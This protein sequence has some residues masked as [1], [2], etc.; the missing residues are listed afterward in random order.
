MRF[1][2]EHWSRRISH[3][4]EVPSVGIGL[5]SK[6]LHRYSQEV[7]ALALGHNPFGSRPTRFSL[8]RIAYFPRAGVAFSR[9]Q[10]NANSFVMELLATVESCLV[11]ESGDHV[12][13]P[14]DAEEL[15]LHFTVGRNNIRALLRIRASSIVAVRRNPY[16][17]T[18]SAF[19][20]KFRASAY[21]QRFGDFEL[22]PAGFEGFVRWLADGGLHANTH[23]AP[24]VH[25]LLPLHYYD[26]LF[27][28]EDLGRTLRAF[29][30]REELHPYLEV[31]P[32]RLGSD[33]SLHNQHAE[34]RLREY[35]SAEARDV[36]AELFRDDFTRLGYS[37][38]IT[39]AYA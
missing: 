8:S 23:W 14:D 35:Y 29:L 22:T 18:L 38:D 2:D 37:T 11:G 36:I 24:Q 16:A 31:W 20:D 3:D 28:Q 33:E 1:E 17:R 21:R 32:Q 26:E 6:I 5:Q 10:K 13:V 4:E 27:P 9:V 7:S 25:S 39:D 15:K 30:E 19:L 34:R 12:D